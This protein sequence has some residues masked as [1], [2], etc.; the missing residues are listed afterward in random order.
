MALEGNITIGLAF[1]GG[2]MA[3][4]DLAAKACSSPQTQH[5]NAKAGRAETSQQWVNIGLL[6]GALFVGIAAVIDP[7]NR[8]AFLAGAGLE[9]AITWLE[10][11]YATKA[12]LASLEQPTEDWGQNPNPEGVNE[13][14]VYQYSQA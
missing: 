9:I 7:R 8:N 10:Y 5:M 3:I 13:N 2:A 6:E 1:L 14:D 12:G 11:R 4:A